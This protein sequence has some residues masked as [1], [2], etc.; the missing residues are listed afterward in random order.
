[1]ALTIVLGQR[2]TEILNCRVIYKL[3]ILEIPD[4]NMEGLHIRK[5]FGGKI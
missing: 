2:G 3:A 5:N 4:T 1:M